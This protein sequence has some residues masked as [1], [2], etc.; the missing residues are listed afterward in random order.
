MAAEQP[1]SSELRA[2]ALVALLAGSAA[3]RHPPG[4]QPE[5]AREKYE[6]K[7]SEK[8]MLQA[9]SSFSCV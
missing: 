9:A 6:I 2:E 3:P 7:S 1:L 4:F 8:Y 5:K